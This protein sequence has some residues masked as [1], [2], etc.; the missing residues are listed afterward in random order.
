VRTPQNICNRHKTSL[1]E[2][3]LAQ[4]SSETELSHAFIWPWNSGVISVR[5]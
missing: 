3:M 4:M 2:D 5:F 1:N